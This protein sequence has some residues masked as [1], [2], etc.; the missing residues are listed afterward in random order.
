MGHENASPEIGF[1]EDIGKRS[2]MIHMETEAVLAKRL[3]NSQ[4]G[5]SLR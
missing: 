2:G 5:A 1:S 3:A 4:V